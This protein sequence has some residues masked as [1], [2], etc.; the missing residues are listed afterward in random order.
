MPFGTRATDNMTESDEEMG[1]RPSTGEDGSVSSSDGGD[2]GESLDLVSELT[3]LAGNH[4]RTYESAAAVVV[5][6]DDGGVDG[7]RSTPP[8][9]L[10]D[11]DSIHTVTALPDMEMR[12]LSVNGAI[13]R[14]G[15]CV[16][17]PS[18]AKVVSGRRHHPRSARS[19][20]S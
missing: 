14:P 4:P 7:R 20:S 10:S 13:H 2:E 12:C 6:G 8:R 18:T 17:R 5:V 9:R 3:P 19:G 16:I 15:N 1:A 11:D